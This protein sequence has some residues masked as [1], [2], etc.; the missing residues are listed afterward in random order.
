[1]HVL[2]IRL[3]RSVVLGLVFCF[4]PLAFAQQPGPS[5]TPSAP[6]PPQIL[7]AKKVFIS[8]AG[9]DD[10]FNALVD[11]GPNRAYNQFYPDMQHWARYQIASSPSDA[12]V[13]FEISAITLSGVNVSNGSGMSTYTPQLRLRIIDPKTQSL[14]WS[15]T[16]NLNSLAGF[17]KTRDKKF[18]AEVVNL[19]NQ[20]KRLVGE[21]LT[22][23]QVS[24]IQRSEGM[25]TGA[26]VFIG[27]MVAAFAVTTAI[28]IHAATSQHS[29]T[30]HTPP[31]CPGFP[32][33]PVL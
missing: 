11:G 16:S 32:A 19:I 10:Y 21:P 1:M 24:A 15:M 8:N 7:N 18:D 30:L 23:S 2:G 9:G 31:N 12:D 28:G 13:V 29:P 25:S 17:K 20:V 33:C 22:A 4:G 5:A 27:V 3:F 6:V 26:K 14:L